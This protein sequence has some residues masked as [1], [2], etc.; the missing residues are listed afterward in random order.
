MTFADIDLPTYSHSYILG[1]ALIWSW[2]V[3]FI[4]AVIFYMLVFRNFYICVSWGQWFAAICCLSKV[5]AGLVGWVWKDF[6]P[7]ELFGRIWELLVKFNSEELRSLSSLFGE[8]FHDW[9]N[10]LLTT[11]CSVFLLNFDQSCMFRNLCTINLFQCNCSEDSPMYPL[12]FCGIKVFF[13]LY[14]YLSG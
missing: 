9:F 8:S 14:F 4:L 3:I 13:V 1:I 5:I 6:F 2:F 12:H 7:F 10:C 11:D